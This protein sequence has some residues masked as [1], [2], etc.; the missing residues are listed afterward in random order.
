MKNAALLLA[1]SLTVPLAGCF[2]GESTPPP[3]PPGPVETFLINAAP[4]AS[5]TVDDPQFGPQVHVL[6]EDNF[7]SASGEN[8][9]R[10]TVRSQRQ[11]AEVVVI[12]R[13]GQGVWRL[14]PRVWG[15][16]LTPPS[17]EKTAAPQTKQAAPATAAAGQPAARPTAAETPAQAAAPAASDAP[18]ADKDGGTES[19]ASSL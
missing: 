3:P 11:E 16:G 10:A 8:C 7:I 12:C 17:A 5:T 2:G 15:Q 6:L 18:A 13:D 9:R 1:L 14:A 19:P 4:G